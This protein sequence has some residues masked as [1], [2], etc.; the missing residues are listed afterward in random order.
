M[1]VFYLNLAGDTAPL[2]D[3]RPT[4]RPTELSDGASGRL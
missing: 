1:Y 4:G 2:E 3:G